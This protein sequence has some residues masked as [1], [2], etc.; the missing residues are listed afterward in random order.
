M[1]GHPYV[2]MA[3]HPDALVAGPPP[4][5]P[6]FQQ[7]C[8][9]MAKKK[10]SRRVQQ[11]VVA[12]P[13]ATTESEPQAGSSM[14]AVRETIESIVIAFVLAFLFRT[15]EAE[16]FV[17]PTGS[18]SPSL[19]G[20]HKDVDCT[21]CGYRFRATASDEGDRRQAAIAELAQTRRN[22]GAL[23]NQLRQT[24]SSW[25]RQNVESNLRRA[26][27]RAK[28]LERL[29]DAYDTVA[30]MCPMCRQTMAM[31]PDLPPGVPNFVDD[32]DVESAD[33]YP[34]DRILV[35]KYAYHNSEPERW[36]VVVF[37]FPGNG[38]MN[39]I[40]R[41]IGLPNETLRVYHGDVF[42]R[43]DSQEQSSFQI[44]RKPTDK[45]SV[46]L[47]PV[48]DTDYDPSLLYE[49]GW[50][51]RW[52]AAANEATDSWQVEATAEELTVKQQYRFESSGNE[53]MQWLR[54]R[55][56]VP[57]DYDWSIVRDFHTTGEHTGTSKEQWQRE[58]L[59]ELIR[60]FNP[61]NANRSR[62]GSGEPRLGGIIENGWDTPEDNYGLNWVGDLALKCNV[63]V[64]RAAGEL[65]L[66]LVEAGQHYTC[67]VDLKTGQ[68]TVFVEGFE[69]YSAQAATP[70]KA[71]GD[72]E[73]QFAN[74]D[75]QLLLWVD[76]ELVELTESTAGLQYDAE[77]V[78]GDRK[79]AIPASSDSDP[80]DLAPA[81]IGATGTSVT[82]N[83]LI[84]L[85]D[86]YYI[87]TNQDKDYQKSDYPRPD[88]IGVQ[89]LFTNPEAWSLFSQRDSVDFSIEEAQ[90]FV[91]G[92]NS[93][94]SS[95]CRLWTTK[96]R[97]GT[98]PGG[99]YLDRRLLIGKA[100]CVFWPHSWGG[101]G[102]VPGFPNFGDMRLVR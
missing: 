87:A 81:G 26:G 20:Q 49:A 93:P 77:V 46:M 11:T 14:Y 2:L 58:A 94:A 4:N 73:L 30:G 42:I 50:P 74:V 80:G 85:R 102:F 12:G 15:F 96:N 88:A 65:A 7:F 54:Y 78:Y 51:L 89:Q 22:I 70:I 48:H 97:E 32:G 71:A 40:K 90:L 91:M 92:D 39:Y 84:L 3:G 29:P 95:D 36:D 64:D 100:I 55:H 59:P 82:V 41:L 8:V 38:E 27:A 61:Y 60:D 33:S 43:D 9:A 47:Q 76:G 35:N 23:K 5:N 98:K 72:Y 63:H 16:A 52:S 99:P 17:I 18:M 66:D 56:Y 6:P 69:E 45:V 34:G 67:R 1:A 44:E 31:R 86:I 24:Q 75:D 21:Q 25:E 62:G 101:I 83:R 37:K 79:N 68:A 19:Q 13:N 53:P 28:S 57:R 10:K